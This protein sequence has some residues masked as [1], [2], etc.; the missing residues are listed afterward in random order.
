MLINKRV[1]IKGT[2]TDY[3]RYMVE[4][5]DATIP[6]GKKEMKLKRI[7]LKSHGNFLQKEVNKIINAYK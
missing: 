3:S 7:F 5:K 4:L 6:A 1:I 2:V